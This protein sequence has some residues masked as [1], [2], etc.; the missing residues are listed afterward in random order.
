MSVFGCLG[1][2]GRCRAEEPQPGSDPARALSN[3]FRRAIGAARPSIV[4]IRTVGRWRD[5]E[6]AAEGFRS[7][8]AT[9]LVVERS[10]GVLTSY[11][12]V[13][14]VDAVFVTL[15]DGREL[16]A[17]EIR[18]DPWSD[19]ALVRVRDAGE[20]AEARWAD[21][22]AVEVGDWVIAAG[23]SFGL[24]FSANP[25]T[26]SGKNREMAEANL[27]LLQTNAPSNP[28]NSGGPLLNL[29]GEVV[30][31]SEGAYSVEGGFDGV[32]F[33][34]PSAA[35]R[36]VAR[37]L[38]ENGQVRWPYLGVSFETL[39]PNVAA[40][41]GLP[42]GLSGAIVSGVVADGPAAKAGLR[43]GDVITECGGREIRDAAGFI[44]AIQTAE[45]GRDFMLEAWREGSATERRVRPGVISRNERP[46]AATDPGE[47]PEQGGPVEPKGEVFVD[48]PLGIAVS[49]LPEDRDGVT[50]ELSGVLVTDVKPNTPAHYLRV[51]P[52]TV[53]THVG[54][55]PVSNVAD[56]RRRSL[57]RPDGT[58]AVLLVS[59]AD[60]GDHFFAL[61]PES[62]I[63]PA[64]V[65]PEG[66]G[67]D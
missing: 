30:G 21:S 66:G 57:A 43:V 1:A 9:G 27:L 38:A 28:G 22:D 44:A 53:V 60:C 16:P 31:I 32:A 46:R 51:H 6:A 36:F 24:G 29:R 20:L 17:S 40:G 35:A 13:A 55:D 8:Y 67:G 47:E 3:S 14:D 63:P 48:S 58:G 37:E 2:A 64:K 7:G 65:P 34:I 41:L 15:P 25:G 19:L 18:L 12:A 23:N 56:F 33:A 49:D 52:G 10:G 39:S 26:V 62:A 5:A 50:R 59:C 4:S 61:R 54:L 42:A 11:H 45:I